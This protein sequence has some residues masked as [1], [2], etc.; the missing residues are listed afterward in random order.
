MKILIT[1]A[2][3]FIGSFLCE[4]ALKRGMDTWAGMREHSSRKWLQQEKLQF[5]FLDM[6]NTETLTQQLTKFKETIGKW[7]I[8]IHAAGA[9]KCL[10]PADFDKHNF[11]C[12]KNLVTTLSSLNML[13]QQFLYVS[14]L[15]V[16][17]PIRE[18][19]TDGKYSDMLSTDEP[20]PNTA[21]G[22]SKVKSEKWL[23]E[24]SLNPQNKDFNYTIF[25]PT[26]VYGPREKDYYLMAQN[27]KAHIDFGAGFK[28]QVITFVYVRDIVGAIF[29]AIGKADIANGKIY[30]VSDGFNYSSR[31]F[32]DLIQKELGIKGVLHI[33]APLWFLRAVCAVSEAFSN[34]TKKP[35]TLNGDKY[36]I[37][38]QRNWQC[39]I[40]P[41]KR[42]LGFSP[43]WPLDRGVKEC[44]AW[45]KDN[46]WL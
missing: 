14:S 29:A 5:A 30:L 19:L 7:D 34:I 15:S 26:G 31:S 36:K 12:T 39:D 23:K 9:T 38:S 33:T 25:R 41:L 16:L 43:E 8:I 35:S 27:I 21:Y 4:E 32:S 6:T 13:P 20:Q 37:M 45:Y 1:G 17:G 24:F 10:D 44:I 11:G 28:P 18:E 46:G 22:H 40:S 42:D 2:S 3:G